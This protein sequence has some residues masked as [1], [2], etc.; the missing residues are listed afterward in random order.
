MVSIWHEPFLNIYCQICMTYT[1]SVVNYILIKPG[2]KG[3]LFPFISPSYPSDSLDSFIRVGIKYGFISCV[4]FSTVNII[5]L[6][7]YMVQA[8]IWLR[9]KVL[10]ISIYFILSNFPWQFLHVAFSIDDFLPP[11]FIWTCFSNFFQ[12]KCDVF[13]LKII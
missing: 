9:K 4:S 12:D 3:K 7:S 13:T 8:F 2:R 10:N 5:I 6:T 11:Q 1:L